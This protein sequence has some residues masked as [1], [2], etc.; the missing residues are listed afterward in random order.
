MAAMSPQGLLGALGAVADSRKRRGVRHRFISILTLCA[1][2]VLARASLFVVIAEWVLDLS[3][4]LRRKLAIG[5][6]P[7]CEST[8]RRVLQRADPDVL[9]GAVLAWLAACSPARARRSVF[10]LDGKTSRGARRLD[11]RAVLM[12]LFAAIDQVGGVVL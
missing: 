5:R 8:I 9:D 2:A 11:G 6:V 4:L 1:C 10:A 12:H 3:L 7:S